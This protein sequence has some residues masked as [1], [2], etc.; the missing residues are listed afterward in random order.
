MTSYL[1]MAAA[2]SLA[3]S[4]PAG[5]PDGKRDTIE[6]RV[7]TFAA[8][9][10]LERYAAFLE[11]AYFPALRR[12]GLGKAGAFISA[13]KPDTLSITLVQAH[14]TIEAYASAENRLLQDAEFHKAGAAVLDLPPDDPPFAHEECSLMLAFESW[15]RLKAP[16][17]AAGNQPRVFELRTYESHSRKANKK[18]I[19]MFNAGE[20]A[21]FARNGLQPVFF[22]ETLSGP[23][24]PNL[25]YM[26]TYPNLEAREGLWKVWGAD[27]EKKR[28]FS[29]PEYADKL[30]VS[31]IHSTFL[32]PLPG[33]MI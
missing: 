32:K 30:I 20:A 5:Q 3:G 31:K 25:T 22:G 9:P 29:I 33:S 19:E 18:K 13:D 12:L 4:A 14:P 21:M 7:L 6:M 26:L 23:Q 10:A 8:K 11:S 16:K 28:L 15:P 1:A 24:I 2:P 17:E 27:P